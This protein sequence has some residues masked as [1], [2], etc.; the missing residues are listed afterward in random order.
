MDKEYE[1][2][3]QDERIA[4]WEF[5][6]ETDRAERD[7]KIKKLDVTQRMAIVDVYKELTTVLEVALYP[8][9]GGIKCVSAYDLQ[10]LD[11][12]RLRLER[13]FNLGID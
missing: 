2:M 8:D 3:T 13:E 7:R 9:M 4:H 12:A 6:R 5:K 1:D 10:E 11:E